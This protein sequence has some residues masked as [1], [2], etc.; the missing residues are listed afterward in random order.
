MEYVCPGPFKNRVE[1]ALRYGSI[2][3]PGRPEAGPVGMNQLWKQY[4]SKKHTCS[5]IVAQILTIFILFELSLCEDITE[6]TDLAKDL[7]LETTQISTRS[8]D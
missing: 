5:I 7:G 6:R 1:V 8:D 2:S 3:V 4:A